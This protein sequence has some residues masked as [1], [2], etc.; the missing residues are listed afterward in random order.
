MSVVT[1]LHAFNESKAEISLK[2]L[3]VYMVDPESTKS[4]KTIDRDAFREYANDLRHACITYPEDEFIGEIQR[5]YLTIG[6]VEVLINSS[7]GE[8][9]LTRELETMC[10]HFHLD[11]IDHGIPTKQGFIDLFTRIT[12][13]DIPIIAKDMVSYQEFDDED[14]EEYVI[15]TLQ[16][17][18]PLA[19][20]LKDVEDSVLVVSHDY[21]GSEVYP[22]EFN[23][24]LHQRTKNIAQQINKLLK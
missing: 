5:I 18:K 14:A 19:K 10:E 23:A 15:Y 6:S 8:D 21:N 1:V 9:Q 17:L 12:A 16:K 13:Q 3:L 20:E 7:L 4:D 24:F 22:D 2:K 11:T